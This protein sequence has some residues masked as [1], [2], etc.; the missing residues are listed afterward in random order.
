MSD[1]HSFKSGRNQK[2]KTQK[3]KKINLLLVINLN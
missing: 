2:V 1:I 3:Q